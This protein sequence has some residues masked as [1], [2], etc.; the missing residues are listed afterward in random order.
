MVVDVVIATYN[1]ANQIVETIDN[2]LQFVDDINKIYVI[3]NNSSDGTKEVLDRVVHE[4]IDITHSLKNLGAPGGKNIGLRKSRADIVIVIDDDAIFFT[5]NPI[6]EVK[7][8]FAE[9]KVLGVVQFKIVNFK[10]KTIQRYEFPG[11]NLE[12]DGDKEFYAGYF[13]GAGHAIRKEILD[14]VGYYPDDFFYAHEEID[15]S[16]KTINE[17]FTIKYFP[18][19]G[20]YH[21]KDPSG[22]LPPNKVIENMYKN[23]LVMTYKYLPLPYAIVSNFLWFVKTLKDSR[24]MIVPINAIKDFL[25]IKPSLTTN[26]LSKS[27][28]EYMKK[29]NGRLYF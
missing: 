20:V 2:V 5:E 28:V 13:I 4:K 25:V 19:V 17:G 22:R 15:L 26:K 21:K 7:R 11:V 24:S 18:I 3:N 10:E 12:A 29:Y 23:R 16:Y 8:I 6:N 9:E 1:R 27:A 14:N